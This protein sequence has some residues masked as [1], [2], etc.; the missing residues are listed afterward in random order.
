MSELA[1]TI[2][3]RI[4]YYRCQLGL[5][6]EKVAEKAG[7]HTS[8]IG[9]LERGEKNATI[10]SIEKIAAAIDIPLS[11]IFDRLGSTEDPD[12]DSD[13]PAKCYDLLLSK[14]KAEQEQLYQILLE[15]DKYKNM[16]M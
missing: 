5:S 6:Q 15:M 2:G 14:S 8:Y 4:K 1:K 11:K 9:Q 12:T 13:I 16:P 3:Q 7:C 10:K